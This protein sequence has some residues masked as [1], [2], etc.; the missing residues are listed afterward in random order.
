MKRGYQVLVGRGETGPV[1]R[2][3]GGNVAVEFAML[4]PVL[5]LMLMGVLDF[6]LGAYQAMAV[7]SAARVGGQYALVHP[8]NAAGIEAAVRNATYIDGVDMTVG[9][10]EYCQCP[11]SSAVSCDT[12]VCASNVAYQ[13]FA[14]VTVSKPYVLMFPFP[15]FPD[16]LTL[17]GAVTLRTQ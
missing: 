17:S 11:G 14:Q 2:T 6:G 13:R 12:G 7:Q 15:G 3:D 10:S 1:R 9:S 5:V 16:S 8:G 4:L